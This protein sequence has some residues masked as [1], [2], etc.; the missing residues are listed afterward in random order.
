MGQKH[1]FDLDKVHALRTSHGLSME[2]LAKHCALSI[3]QLRQIEE[4]GHDA[5]YSPAIKQLAVRKVLSALQDVDG[6]LRSQSQWLA[7]PDN[8][9]VQWGPRVLAFKSNSLRTGRSANGV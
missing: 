1:D 6:L 7:R 8:T 2:A 5:F 4:G 3:R 9:P